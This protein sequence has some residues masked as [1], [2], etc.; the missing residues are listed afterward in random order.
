MKTCLPLAAMAMVLSVTS[1]SA[2]F[3]R[4]EIPFPFHVGET[5]LKAG[6]YEIAVRQPFGACVTVR[7]TGATNKAAIA[8][9]SKGNQ[10]DPS[11]H[12]QAKLVFNRYS[13]SQYFLSQIWD[14]RDSTSMGLRKSKH[15]LVTS[16]FVAARA[17]EKV[18]IVA[19]ASLP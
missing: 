8:F 11:A 10:P 15:E 5:Q 3:L 6:S 18:V 14:P 19:T 16:K 13:E 9:F 7:S 12:P 4:V 1:A 2:Q 17:P